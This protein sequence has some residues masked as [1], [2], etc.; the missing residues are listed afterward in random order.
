MIHIKKENNNIENHFFDIKKEK[1]ITNPEKT[2]TNA[3]KN[4]PLILKIY[5]SINGKKV[6]TCTFVFPK[7]TVTNNVEK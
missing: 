6:T 1:N 3:E 2:N 7:K 5:T 4:K